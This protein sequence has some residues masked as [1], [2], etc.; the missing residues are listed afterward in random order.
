MEQGKTQMFTLS[1]LETAAALVHGVM[2]PTPQ[3]LLAAPLGARR[4]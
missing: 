4:C 3:I 1:Q 2:P